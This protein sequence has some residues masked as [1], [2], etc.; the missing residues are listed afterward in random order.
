[1]KRVS[2][3]GVIMLSNNALSALSQSEERVGVV[4]AQ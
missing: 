4:C 3:V 2:T 1:V